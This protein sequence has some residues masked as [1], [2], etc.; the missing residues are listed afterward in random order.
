MSDLRGKIGL[1]TTSILAH[2][3][4]NGQSR[5]VGISINPHNNTREKRCFVRTGS[6]E[7]YV[8]LLAKF[9]VLMVHVRCKTI[10]TRFVLSIIPTDCRGFLRIGWLRWQFVSAG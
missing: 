6:T 1:K 3:S 2:Y 9:A 7:L 8:E 5:G 4:T 10:I